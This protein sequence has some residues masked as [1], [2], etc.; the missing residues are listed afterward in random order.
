MTRVGPAALEERPARHEV[1]NAATLWSDSGFVLVAG[2]APWWQDQPPGAIEQFIVGWMVWL[3]IAVE[4][5]VLS[6]GSR[7]WLSA[8]LVAAGFFALA[9]PPAVWSRTGRWVTSTR[10]L[11]VI[12]LRLLATISLAIGFVHSKLP[13]LMIALAAGT[14]FGIDASLS[15]RGVGHTISPRR[16]LRRFVLS[17]LHLGVVIGIGV[18][19]LVS[20]R[21]D[22]PAFALRR[23]GV[24]WLSAVIGLAMVHTFQTA[25]VHFEGERLAHRWQWQAEEHRRRAHW[26]HDDVCAE[27]RYVRIRVEQG[28]LGSGALGPVLDDLDHRLRLRQLDELMESGSVRLAEVVQPFLRTMQDRG[29]RIVDVPGFDVSDRRLASSAARRLRR[30]LGVAVPNALQAGATS[31]GIR[32]RVDGAIL[33][34]EVEDDAGGFDL[35]ATPPGRGLD[36]LRDELGEAAIVVRRS[37]HGSIVCVEMRWDD[38]MGARG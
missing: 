5:V 23:Y 9:A 34:V 28:E 14:F 31:L 24:L 35:D 18:M 3:A 36:G 33:R 1:S 32:I 13:D 25:A 16:A 26:I 19:V 37:E 10:P 22:D 11:A 29:V 27:L 21:A 15:L 6:F 4:L 38:P 7:A 12:P 8:A 17:G 2:P 20:N 30:V